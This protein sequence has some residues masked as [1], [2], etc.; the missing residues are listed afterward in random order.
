MA[1]RGA[2]LLA[3]FLVS[4][5]VSISEPKANANPSELY[6]DDG[7]FDIG[8]SD[9]HPIAA[10]VRFSP[11]SQFW[12]IEAIKLHG[13]CYLRG[14]DTNFVLEIWDEKLNA[15]YH[16]GLSLYST[17]EGKN[18]T[19]DWHTIEV[20]DLLVAGGFY[21]VVAPC[22]TLDGPQLWISVDDDPPVD[23]E[24]F[25]V[26][27]SAHKLIG[28]L[29]SKGSIVGDF[30]VRVVGGPAPA[31]PELRLTSLDFSKE[32][33]F[34]HFGLSRGNVLSAN[35]SL[36]L[37]D[38]EEEACEVAIEG[39][40]A[41]SVITNG[42]GVLNV[43]VTTDIGTVGASLEL[44]CD[45]RSQYRELE[46]EFSIFRVEAEA[47]SSRVEELKRENI[48]LRESLNATSLNA[49]YLLKDVKQLNQSIAIRDREIEGLRGTCNALA[50]GFAATASLLLILVLLRVRAKWRI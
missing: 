19:L 13:A 48:M 28:A 31:P 12:R 4:T 49:A 10:A 22:L 25:L 41:F 5:L 1:Q 2:L 34:L 15:V 20:P 44:G 42:S 14:E 38:G 35:A 23:N 16:A 39:A 7:S 33:T 11:P 45:L 47:M 6:Y 36:L 50:V 30:M 3:V 26:D 46:S 40:S 18:S 37:A 8:W 32:K 29:G 21:V 24:S 27:V 9:F 17:F 43:C